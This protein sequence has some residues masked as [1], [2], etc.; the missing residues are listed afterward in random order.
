MASQR[1]PSDTYESPSMAE[2]EQ[3][4][5]R[6]AKTSAERLAAQHKRQTEKEKN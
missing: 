1:A 3:M 2:I 4:Q 6:A 5:T